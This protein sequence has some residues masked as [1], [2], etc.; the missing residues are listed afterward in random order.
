MKA[1]IN[2]C[3]NMFERSRQV[4]AWPA[5]RLDTALREGNTPDVGSAIPGM[6]LAEPK[7]CSIEEETTV[8]IIR[9]LRFEASRRRLSSHG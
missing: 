4:S 5:T 2:G 6:G 8:S 7:T 1:A 9:G 3:P